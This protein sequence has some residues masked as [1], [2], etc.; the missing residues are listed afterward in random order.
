VDERVAPIVPEDR[1]NA[2]DE[3]RPSAGRAMDVDVGVGERIGVGY[4]PRIYSS[5][6]WTGGELTVRTRDD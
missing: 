2:E 4:Q 6:G 3:F 1:Q 5:I